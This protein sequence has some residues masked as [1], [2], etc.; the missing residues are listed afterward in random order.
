MNV[1]TMHPT[2]DI[3]SNE[4]VEERAMPHRQKRSL[5][6]RLESIASLSQLIR[7]FGAC[8][9]LVSMSL[10]MLKGWS[11]GNDISRYL[12]LLAQTGLLSGAGLLLTFLIKEFKGARVFFG[13]ALVSVVANFTIL[14]SLTY[15][16]FA[17]DTMIVDYPAMMKWEVINA[18]TFAPVFLG[19]VA[20]LSLV[21]FFGFSVFARQISKPLTIGFLSLCTLLLIPVR[22]SLVATCLAAFAL[23]VAW[24][25]IKRL[26]KVEKLAFTKEAKAA[27]G[28]L[29]L[30][31]LII[32]A[33]A[34]S[35][36]HIDEITLLVVSALA[37][38]GLRSITMEM[39]VTAARMLEI[40]QYALGMVIALLVGDILP[41]SFGSF[42]FFIPMLVFIGFATEQLINGREP[43]WKSVMTTTTTAITAPLILL[44]AVSETQFIYSLQALVL[45][46]TLLALNIYASK[47][48]HKP[49]AGQVMSIISVIAASLI[50]FFD[51]VHLAQLG[52]WMIIGLVG[53]GLI[54]GASI[55]ERY[56]LSLS[57]E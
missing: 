42:S 38:A 15:S 26:S 43:A 6:E 18:T 4:P 34:L 51:L 19:A 3:A 27:L 31:G 13:L 16:L 44:L 7:I 56:G 45:C 54:L 52:S 28:M 49:V 21:S 30:P 22:S 29:L 33:R 2:A 23:W 41:S 55:Y 12:K 39:G 47:T 53:G 20:L 32:I 10:F 48:L 11:D 5:S 24:M 46:G 40:A 14:G 37:F 9:I 36:Y 25:L 1:N 35:F 17:I 50:V 8:A 57:K